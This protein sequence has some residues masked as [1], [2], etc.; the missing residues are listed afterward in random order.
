MFNILIGL[1]QHFF[2]IGSTFDFQNVK[3]VKMNIKIKT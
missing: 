3:T 2:K 1:T